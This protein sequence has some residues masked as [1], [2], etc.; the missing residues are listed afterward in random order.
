MTTLYEAHRNWR[1]RPPDERY[2]SLSAMYNEAHTRHLLSVISVVGMQDLKV[3]VDPQYDQDVLF[4]GGNFSAKPTHWS[5]GQLGTLLNLPTDWLRTAPSQLV[6]DSLK[7]GI[8]QAPRDALQMLWYIPKESGLPG[9]MRAVTTTTYR[10][11]WDDDLIQMLLDISHNETTWGR[12]SAH[13]DNRYPSGYYMSDRDLWIFMVSLD[14][15]IADGELKRGF[16][17]WNT[18]VQGGFLQSFGMKAFLYQTVC[19]NHIVWGAQNLF[20]L[21]M[22]HIG[23]DI[24]SRVRY[25]VLDSVSRYFDSSPASEERQIAA[26]KKFSLGKTD[27]QVVAWLRDRGITQAAAKEAIAA[28]TERN[29]NPFTLWAIVVSLTNLSQRAQ[30]MSDRS[31]LDF[32]AGKLLQEVEA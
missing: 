31:R 24:Y 13:T 22:I 29:V 25:K 16:F 21:R 19:G 8:S 1:Q 2:A 10:H 5:F 12:P 4:T 27:E 7:F 11:L 30:W 17:L 6:V 32:Q 18:E 9:L 26:A 15:P 23:Q 20:D 14:H 3:E 28:A